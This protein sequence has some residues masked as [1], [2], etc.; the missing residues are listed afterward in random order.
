MA[1]GPSSFS[2]L[3][4]GVA[5]IIGALAVVGLVSLWSSE[6]G[7][8]AGKILAAF[9]GLAIAVVVAMS[10]LVVVRRA[11]V[12]PTPATAEADINGTIYA[13][14]PDEN[15]TPGSRVSISGQRN[16][17][18][19][20]TVNLQAD[21]SN[22]PTPGVKGGDAKIAQILEALVEAVRESGQKEAIN[23]KNVA[24]GALTKVVTGEAISPTKPTATPAATTPATSTATTP[25]AAS[26]PNVAAKTP[27]AAPTRPEPDWVKTRSDYAKGVLIVATDPCFSKQEADALMAAHLKKE[28]AAY[29][30]DWIDPRAGRL[31][32]LPLDYVRTKLVKEEWEKHHTTSVGETIQLFAM[33]QIDHDA[34]VRIEQQWEQVCATERLFKL[35]G[36]FG[37]ILYLLAVIHFYLR[38]DLA[39]AGIYRGRLR[40]ISIGLFLAPLAAAI[41]LT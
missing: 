35:G 29:V 4:L 30:S 28:L 25:A 38:I 34:K 33:V 41:A 20:Y 26:V 39:T 17:S 3:L 2:I 9:G 22:K 19:G 5:L 37:G 13:E 11:Q 24:Q 36:G 32:R 10:L 21:V 31:V 14:S 12:A 23:A 8:M 6:R 16:A 27:T 40:L 1:V 7:R 15:A 18:G